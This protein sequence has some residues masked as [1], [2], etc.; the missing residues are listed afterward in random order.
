MVRYHDGLARR[1]LDEALV[2]VLFQEKARAGSDADEELR[3]GVLLEDGNLFGMRVLGQVK[4]RAPGPGV[5]ED[6]GPPGIGYKVEGFDGLFP[7]QA[8]EKA[9]IPQ[10][11]FLDERVMGIEPT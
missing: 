9:N 7:C 10:F 2:A 5:A 1:E 3:A 8:I 6:D 11:A 4:A